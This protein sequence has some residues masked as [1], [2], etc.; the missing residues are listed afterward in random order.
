MSI[1]GFLC[2]SFAGVAYLDGALASQVAIGMFAA[3]VGKG[4]VGNGNVRTEDAPPPSQALW[5]ERAKAAYAAALGED[6]TPVGLLKIEKLDLRVPVFMGTKP[7]VLNRGAGV[8]EGTAAPGEVGNIAI[9]GHR[10]SFFRALKDIA[11]GDLIELVSQA[12]AQ[13]YRVAKLSIV[14]PLDVSPLE[15]STTPMLTIITC[16]PFY[17]VGSAPDRF[18]VRALPVESTLAAGG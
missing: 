1:A 14:D 3:D 7:L 4:N 11:V 5:S 18:V 8:I 12:G 15:S 13:T 6:F 10:D 2:L 17:Y 16:H 9:S